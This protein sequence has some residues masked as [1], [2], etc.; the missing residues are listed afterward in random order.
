MVKKKFF[1][2][3]IEKNLMKVN[4]TFNQDRMKN[5]FF[6]EDQASHDDRIDPYRRSSMENI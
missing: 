2:K 6:F 5:I 4:P 3:K 1:F